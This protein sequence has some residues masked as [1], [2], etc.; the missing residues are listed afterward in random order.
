MNSMV[1]WWMEVNDV[2]VIVLSRKDLVMQMS[3]VH[4]ENVITFLA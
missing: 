3:L 4:K 2:V 1:L